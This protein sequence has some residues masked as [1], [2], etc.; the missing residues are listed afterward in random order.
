MKGIAIILSLIVLV[1]TIIPC[2]DGNNTEDQYRDEISTNHNHQNDS[3]DTCALTCICNCCG[4]VIT[5]QP[6]ATFNLG[7]K[8]QI[9][10]E[11]VSV[12]ISIY[13]FNFQYN[14]W[15]PPQLIS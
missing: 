6:L 2:S 11:M 8:N 3:D 4:T 9:L 7:L 13:R 12:H 5:Y 14:I 10:R 1:L 15:Q